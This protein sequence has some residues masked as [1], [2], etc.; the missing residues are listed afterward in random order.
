MIEFAQSQLISLIAGAVITSALL[1]FAAYESSAS[2]DGAALAVID[3]VAVDVAAVRCDAAHAA[4]N[5]TIGD[6]LRALPDA[7]D[8]VDLLPSHLRAH[9]RDGRALVS[10]SFEALPL[11]APLHLSSASALRFAW[12]PLSE[13]CTITVL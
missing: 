4:T 10:V 9:F 2:T 13:S 1:G 3:G 12:D 7:V 8:S 11:L 6:R 5:L